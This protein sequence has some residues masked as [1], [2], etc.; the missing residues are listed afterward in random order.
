MSLSQLKLLTWTFVFGLGAYAAYFIVDF[1]QAKATTAEP[2]SAKDWLAVMDSVP[3]IEPIRDDVVAYHLIKRTWHEMNMTGAGPPLPPAPPGPQL[4]MQEKRVEE[5]LQVLMVNVDQ[6]DTSMSMASVGYLDD[7]LRAAATS[8]DDSV[9]RES[10]KLHAPYDHIV[11]KS[12]RPRSVLFAFTDGR[13]PEL[14]ESPRHLSTERIYRLDVEVVLSV[15]ETP[16]PHGRG[17]LDDGRVR[18]GHE[19]RARI[20]QDFASIL[21]E[22]RIEPHRDLRTG[23]IDG[24]ELKEVPEGA[25]LAKYGAKQGQVVRSLNGHPV[26]SISEALSFAKQNTDKYDVWVLV[27]DEQG[28]EK[29][30]VIDE[31]E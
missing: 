19:D 3:L 21:A 30:L 8:M 25:F 2:V 4:A 16:P 9:L 27:Y 17:H 18:I 29:T 10:D 23:K 13:E 31:T 1:E 11:V 12:I 26:K 14:V 15:T 28:A 5:L 7:Q 20:D 22:V 6:G 24:L